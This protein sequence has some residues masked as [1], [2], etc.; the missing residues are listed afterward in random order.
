MITRRYLRAWNL[1]DRCIG[2]GPSRSWRPCRGGLA[3]RMIQAGACGL[4]I[5][6]CVPR[7]PEPEPE[8]ELCNVDTDCP[9][10]DEFCN[11]TQ[12]CVDGECV[13]QPPGCDDDEVCDDVTDECRGCVSDEECDDDTFCN[14]V[15]TCVEGACVPGERACPEDKICDETAE[16]CTDC[17]NDT[18]C[19]DGEFCNGEETCVDG[20][21]TPGETPCDDEEVCSE[22]DD[23]CRQPIDPIVSDFSASDEDWTVAGNGGSGSQA[24]DRSAGGGRP[25]GAVSV[26]TRENGWRWNAPSKFLGDLSTV[27]GRSLTFDL[28]QSLTDV[29]LDHEDDVIL[30]G[31]GIELAFDLSENPGA[32]WTHFHVPLVETDARW[33]NTATGVRPT[34]S[35]MRAVLGAL[36]QLQIRGDF[37]DRAG[38][39]AGL[40]NVI[41]AVDDTRFSPIVE[42]AVST[43]EVND[44][45]WLVVGNSTTGRGADAPDRTRD[46]GRPGGSVSAETRRVGWF[47]DAPAGFTGDA[48]AAHGRTLTFELYQSLIDVQ[49]E[50]ADD[51]ILR[52]GGLTLHFD[53]PYNPD[54]GWTAYSVR[55]DESDGRWRVL[56]TGDRPT[57]D[58]FRAVLAALGQIQ[59]RGSFRDRDGETTGLE[60]VVLDVGSAPLPVRT[61]NVRSTFDKDT[62]GWLVLG[63]SAAGLGSQQPDYDDDGGRPGGNLVV[64][65]ATDHGW[66]WDAP[67]SF[68]GD[69]SAAAMRQ[70]SF[71]LYQSTTD[72]QVDS[73]ADVILRG[74]GLTLWWDHGDELANPNEGWTSY[75]VIFDAADARWLNVETQ[76]RPTDDEMRSVLAEL[77]QLSIRGFFRDRIGVFG[78]LDNVLL[79]VGSDEPPPKSGTFRS[80]F[81]E[82]TEGWLVIGNSVADRGADAPEYSGSGGDPGEFIFAETAVNHGWLFDAPDTFLGDATN[83]YQRTLSFEMFQSETDRQL[84]DTADVILRG[85]GIV[86]TYDFEDNP[87]EGWTLF[88]V[89]LDETDRGWTNAATLTRPTADE[90]RAVLGS[91]RQLSILGDR[92]DVPGAVVGLDNVVLNSP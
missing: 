33:R 64:E 84:D 47:W 16:T 77:R 87:D 20:L 88:T 32:G 1:T 30:R 5:L 9:N 53:L 17:T 40:D 62:E 34:Q 44:E 61:E 56:E 12:T 78:G 22:E 23:A 59:I 50:Y 38:A 10:D 70:L 25:G 6:A 65:T 86:L 90:M 26:E 39:V 51:V 58:E 48:S 71:D 73:P 55:L 69:V 46:S 15:E 52:G 41:I 82:G 31:D 11:G 67:E 14:G 49:L 68:L 18:H 79:D 57:A 85:A 92:R 54:A 74:G 19:A 75:T 91:L 36:G 8:P 43:F 80:G 63:N 4:L 89:P 72:V 28:Y 2:C 7:P 83:A 66:Y 29:Q 42:N 3:T 37:R 21:C 76:V 27:Y 45:G 24:P 60:N 35:E 13:L 81:D